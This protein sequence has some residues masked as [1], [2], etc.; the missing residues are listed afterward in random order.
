MFH[1]WIRPID[2]TSP[3]G[4]Q[5]SSYVPI[6]VLRLLLPIVIGPRR[7]LVFWAG[8]ILLNNCSSLVNR[9]WDDVDMASVE[10]SYK[11]EVFASYVGTRIETEEFR[12]P[13]S[14]T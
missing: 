12:Q 7:R 13:Q 11:I 4:E 3:C 14:D 5:V 10:T 8:T 6:Y 1:K 2:I 9:P